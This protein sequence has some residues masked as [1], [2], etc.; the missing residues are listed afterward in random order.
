MHVHTQTETNTPILLL[1]KSAVAYYHRET[2]MAKNK[3]RGEVIMTDKR[4]EKGGGGS[5]KVNTE[6]M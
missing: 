2:W 1:H 6:G 5:R 4:L 3:T